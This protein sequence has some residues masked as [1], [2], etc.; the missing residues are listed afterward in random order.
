MTDTNAATVPPRTGV[1]SRLGAVRPFLVP[2][3]SVLVAASV[4]GAGLRVL[5]TIALPAIVVGA[6]AHRL[7]RAPRAALA[8][9]L[10]VLALVAG[11]I[12]RDALLLAAAVLF[13][14]AGLV[15]AW[16]INRGR[17]RARAWLNRALAAVAAVLVLLLVVYPTALAVDYAAKPRS[18]IHEDALALPHERVTFR[19][20]D[21][22]RLSGWYI[23]RRNRGA[24]VVVHGGGGDR[25][26]ALRHA[27]MLAAAGY[28]VLLYDA[29][30]RGESAGHE[31]ALGWRW[32]RD[33]RGAVDFLQRRGAR[34]IGLLGLSTGAEAV[35]TEAASDPRI[36][37]VVA[38]GL[39]GRSPTD[40]SHLPF[41]D[42]ILI[43]PAFAVID[44]ELRLT[45]GESPPPPLMGLV[46]RYAHSRPLLLIATESFERAWNR[47]YADGTPAELWQ[48]PGTPH[49]G[50]LAKHSREYRRRVLDFFHRAVL[51]PPRA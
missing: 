41:G 13:L 51:G 20:T 50:G 3:A 37:A 38:D 19:A 24:I 35:V 27:R 22:V 7:P 29:R 42:R 49:T 34:L 16:G 21:G 2:A 45:R 36:R 25:E 18:P 4:L 28:G 5:L 12:A 47:A 15:D 8:L 9:L 44:L 6:V 14:L 10:G 33:V 26:G 39:Q 32:H 30:G 43:Q 48:L 17:S 23:P 40:A 31:N 46:H 11:L 1:A